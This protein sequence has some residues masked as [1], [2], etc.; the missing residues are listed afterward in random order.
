MD[1]VTTAAI[2]AKPRCLFLRCAGMPESNIDKRA[3][4]ERAV[5]KR[6]AEPVRGLI[7]D[8]RFKRAAR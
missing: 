4:E 1:T 7:P 3:G 2:A 5:A 8:F 6:I